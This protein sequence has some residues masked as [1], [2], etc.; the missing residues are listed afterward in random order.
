[1]PQKH[2]KTHKPLHDGADVLPPSLIEAVDAFI[3]AC[4]VRRTRGQAGEHSSMLVHVTRFIDVQK[5]VHRQLSEHVAHIR[6]RIL[7]QIG[8]EE[9]V[10]RLHQLW[11]K[12]FEPT[13]TEVFESEPK[14]ECALI[15]SWNDVLA[16]LA[17]TLSDID[18]RMINGTA[19]DALDY[20]ERQATGLK[21]IAVG[22]DK[23]AR[24]LTL[25]GLCVSYFLRASKM[26]D[27]LMQMGRWFGYR[28]G[29]LDLSRLYTTSEL[30]NWFGHIAD[31]SEEL[32][33]EFDLMAASGATPRDYGLKV[34]SHSVLMVT[35]RL[36]MRTA[37]NL[38]LS[39]SGQL[40]ETVSL[41]SDPQML[42]RNLEAAQEL[43]SGLGNPET[44][45]NRNRGASRQQWKGFLWDNVP[46]SDIVDFLS[47]YR[48]HPEAYK[49]NSAL[50]AEF[51]N[52]MVTESQLTSWT[53]AVIGGGEGEQC[54]LTKGVTVDMLKRV[55]NG[56]HENRYAIGRLLSPRDEAI[57]LDEAAWE[58]AL[59][60]TRAA[61]HSDPARLRA[62]AEPEIP[63]G[64]AIRKIRGFGA[65]GVAA[66]PER[67]VLLIYALDPQQAEL[68]LPRGTPPVIA[69]GVSFPGSSSGIKVEYKVNNVLWEQEYGPA[70]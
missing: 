63:N 6:Q 41:Y 43:I 62:T 53:I 1:M 61:W 52:A 20:V 18:V 45:P 70:E 13:S 38:M 51:I 48:T 11:I 21:V 15:P 24:G 58:A 2:N 22:G 3:L 26:Y 66:H 50:L 12:D 69:I 40:L 33:E 55:N 56:P 39:F 67:G 44:N 35:S 4:A 47:A 27:T 25:E 19:K 60:A 68:N 49:V 9:I 14:Q 34:Q 30:T 16:T 7:R 57:D 65:G 31:A 29:Y 59:A 36:K 42:Q 54:E 28:P 46:A 32:R 64:P 8:H 37:K 5:E 10:A 17:E 23:L